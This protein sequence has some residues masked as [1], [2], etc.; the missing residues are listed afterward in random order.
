M[1]IDITISKASIYPWTPSCDCTRP[2][3]FTFDSKLYLY[4]NEWIELLDSAF[5]ISLEKN[6]SV[7]LGGLV[8]LTFQGVSAL[9]TI[10]LICSELGEELALVEFSEHDM[11]VVKITKPLQRYNT[12]FA[13][14]IRDLCLGSSG[15]VIQ[16]N[17]K[18]DIVAGL[19]CSKAAAEMKRSQ[20]I[21]GVQ[22]TYKGIR[23]IS[24]QGSQESF[25]H[26]LRMYHIS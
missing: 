13:Y 3:S 7:C 8:P 21:F 20:G 16:P 5:Q 6:E 11:Y 19:A 9:F 18:T 24:E 10:V 22:K 14:N 23:L 1:R 26:E 12:K 4:A 17:Y 25:G 2:E 15:P